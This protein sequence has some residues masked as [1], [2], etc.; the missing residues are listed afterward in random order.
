MRLT[1]YII[2]LHIGPLLFGTSAVVF[3]FLLQFI[4]KALNNLIGK[5]LSYWVITKLITLNL[6][7]MLV[8]AVP[9]GVL[10][11]TLMAY[12]KL[13]G[14]NELTIVKSSGGS[15]F[16]VMMPAIVGGAFLFL[17]L[18]LFNDRVLPEANHRAMVLQ[19][20]IQN[21][22]KTFAI[23]PGQFTTL[24]GYSILA[25]RVDRERDEL[26][27]VTIYN[28]D[29]ENLNVINAKRAEINFARDFSRLV[30]DL[31]Q[32]EVQQI[33]RRNPQM[34]RKFTFA[35]YRVTIVTSGYNFSQSDPSSFG[36]TD[37][38][39]NIDAM[40]AVADTAISHSDEAAVRIDSILSRQLANLSAP[41]IDTTH[42]TRAEAAQAALSELSVV[43][44]QLESESINR[45]E[46]LKTADQY[47][48]EIHK[49]YSI[50]A[51]CFV[52][53]FVGAPLGILVKRGNFGVS[54][55]IALGFFIIYWACLVTG[56]KLA[57]RA[58]LSPAV[59]MWMAD[60]VI[61]V[62]G[63]YLTVLVSRETVTFNFDFSWLRR[64][65]GIG[66]G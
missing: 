64:K 47:Y 30:M 2:R 35:T 27:D 8:L 25:R 21:L 33:D 14:S 19:N 66:R 12:G 3:I 62:L 52:F 34:F 60:F 7:W 59:A 5:G 61:G 15:A 26:L 17:A 43:R 11:S 28:Q 65:K 63:A 36:R 10:V 31:H 38:T 40:K 44:S 16:R 24:Q 42:P 54:A 46:Q 39:M 56:E 1:W 55:A 4:F 53:V 20:D 18:F 45:S 29:G 48:V 37:R 22:N 9:M 32:G 51:A 58:V 57:D 13:S 49:K 6:A 23:E 50:P 41:V